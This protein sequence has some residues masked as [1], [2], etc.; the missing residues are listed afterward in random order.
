M[1]CSLYR[2]KIRERSSV[3]QL[4]S[5]FHSLQISSQ[6]FFKT[7]FYSATFLLKSSPINVKTILRI[8]LIQIKIVLYAKIEE[9][10]GKRTRNKMI[11]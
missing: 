9:I 2:E 3:V 4:V 10:S 1:A 7:F 8:K 11:N 6:V 5:C